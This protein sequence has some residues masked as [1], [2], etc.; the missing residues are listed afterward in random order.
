MRKLILVVASVMGFL[1]VYWFLMGKNGIV[2]FYIKSQKL[3]NL[4]QYKYKLIERKD[5][6]RYAISS[7]ES[8]KRSVPRGNKVIV[9][10]RVPEFV[11]LEP[12]IDDVAVL[13]SRMERLSLFF[14][15]FVLV[16][17]SVI[18]RFYGIKK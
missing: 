3:Y 14:M 13:R 10:F 6:L 8:L 1:I 11:H 12:E 15:F 5:K 7:L 9:R 17:V 2:D 16:G 4:R 18:G